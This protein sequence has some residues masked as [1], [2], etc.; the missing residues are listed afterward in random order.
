MD[1]SIVMVPGTRIVFVSLNICTLAIIYNPEKEKGKFAEII[2][3]RIMLCQIQNGV[4]SGGEV[5]LGY[6]I[7]QGEEFNKFPLKL[8]ALGRLSTKMLRFV[9]TCSY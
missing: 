8:F 7:D 9:T 6:Q 4:E 5:G 3:L 2:H 1:V